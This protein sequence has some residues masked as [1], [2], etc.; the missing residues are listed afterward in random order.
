MEAV[1]VR[2]KVCGITRMEDATAAVEAGADALGFIF[3]KDSP[4]NISPT[5]A[6]AIVRALPP[7]VSTVGGFV[8][9][10]QEEVADFMKKAGLAV[11]QLH[12][13]E[14]PEF[15]TFFPRV[16]KAVR[17]RG[18]EDL[19][20]LSSYT[21]VSAFLLDAYSSEAYGGTGRRLDWT[22]AEAAAKTKRIILAGGLD[23]GNVEEAVRTVRP[24]GV[25]VSSG[26]ESSPGIKDHDLIREFVLRAKA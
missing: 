9:R 23:P 18:A 19:A 12:G 7:F 26:V 21:C 6:G 10:V 14:S 24:Y 4:R 20:G 15:C 1:P 25:D 16:I 11:A 13:D 3:H 22:L 2:V 8:N 17:V 5:E